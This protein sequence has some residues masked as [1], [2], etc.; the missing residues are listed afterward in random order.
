MSRTALRILEQVGN[1]E[2][3][4]ILKA[5]E[6]DFVGPVIKELEDILRFSEIPITLDVQ[7]YIL[8]KFEKWYR[9]FTKKL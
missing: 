7:E 5:T 4:K 8:E 3:K 9:E 1:E 2:A 6:V